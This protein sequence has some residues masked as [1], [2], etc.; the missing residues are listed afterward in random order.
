MTDEQFEALT[1][2]LSRIIDNQII[3]GNNLSRVENKLNTL[4]EDMG[5]S[6]RNENILGHDQ[7]KLIADVKEVLRLLNKYIDLNTRT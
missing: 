4:Q 3:I 6:I 5:V 2:Q 7:D 1:K